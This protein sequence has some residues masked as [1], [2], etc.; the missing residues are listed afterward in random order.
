MFPLQL[1]CHQVRVLPAHHL[2]S[3]ALPQRAPHHFTEDGGVCHQQEPPAPHPGGC[4]FY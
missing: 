4:F 1:L 2:G 3:G